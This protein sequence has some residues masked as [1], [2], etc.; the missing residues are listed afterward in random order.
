MPLARTKAPPK[1]TFQAAN[2]PPSHNQARIAEV[3]TEAE[4]EA[5]AARAHQAP[6]IARLD[7]I[8]EQVSATRVPLR[9]GRKLYD[10][11]QHIAFVCDRVAERD[12]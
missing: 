5:D 6:L 4:L 1:G 2:T 3:S 9:Y 7:R 12:P 11:R 10:L 8:T